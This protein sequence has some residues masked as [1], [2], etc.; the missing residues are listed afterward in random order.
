MLA[1]VRMLVVSGNLLQA[2]SGNMKSRKL[3]RMSED[4]KAYIRGQEF[5]GE[6][7]KSNIRVQAIQKTWVGNMAYEKQGIPHN[8]ATPMKG[9]KFMAK[10]PT[11]RVQRVR[12]PGKIMTWSAPYTILYPWDCDTK[13]I[14]GTDEIENGPS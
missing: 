12:D 6:G 7:E 10:F 4:N 14:L 8:F 9:L 2:K 3:C 11:W 13:L 5:Q 1:D